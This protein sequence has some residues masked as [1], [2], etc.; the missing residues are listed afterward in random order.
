MLGGAL[1]D[2]L[3][4]ALWAALIVWLVAFVRPDWSPVRLGA[5][6]LVVCFAVELSQMLRADWLQAM[7]GTLPGHLVL[8]SDFDARDLVAYTFG[9]ALAV[10]LD[11]AVLRRRFSARRG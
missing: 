7:R 6:A 8:G 2:V 1:R 10:W 4:D 3:G 9:V 5:T 11:D